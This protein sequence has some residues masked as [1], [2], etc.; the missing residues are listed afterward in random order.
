MRHE[1]RQKFEEEANSGNWAIVND[2]CRPAFKRQAGPFFQANRTLSTTAFRL[3][4]FGEEAETEKFENLVKRHV[5][6]SQW[7]NTII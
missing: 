1:Q 3:V 2:R 7:G 6:V 5:R 4:K